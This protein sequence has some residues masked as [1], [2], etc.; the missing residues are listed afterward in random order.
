MNMICNISGIL[1]LILADG[2]NII[3]LWNESY[4]RRLIH[5]LTRSTYNNLLKPDINVIKQI[6]P[7][8][9]IEKVKNIDTSK[10][11][12]GSK[13][14]NTF[15]A[16][17]STLSGSVYSKKKNLYAD[18]IGEDDKELLMR[19]SDLV[20]PTFEKTINKKLYLTKTSFSMCLL[21][22]EGKKSEFA[23]HYD[24]EPSHCYRMILLYDKHGSCPAFLYRSDDKVESIS[25]EIGDCIFFRG[26]KTYHAVEQ[27]KDEAS[28]RY[29]LGF[30]FSTDEAYANT[31]KYDKTLC[32]L[33]SKSMT[34]TIL[35]LLP[36]HLFLMVLYHIVKLQIEVNFDC[37]QS[38]IST[39]FLV[40]P[41]SFFL[42][43][44]MPQTV[45]T[46]LNS[47]ALNI[48]RLFLL[49]MSITFNIIDSSMLLMYYLVTEA[50]LPNN[51]VAR[52]LH[53]Y[54]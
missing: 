3:T 45:G 51:M 53:M 39:W 41:L 11:D 29:V 4:I 49:F 25:L 43:S 38:L 23:W 13:G 54:D 16:W 22:Y 14:I 44:K 7:K 30:Q 31:V 34:E 1:S 36:R 19:I 37:F 48:L 35:T 8:E 20:K 12:Q 32:S 28:K 24:S 40:V 21:R 47:D 15:S 18:N 50:T 2:F 27:I 6:L 17:L 5:H 26:T 52:H 10:Y 46:H 33:R 9:E 42:P